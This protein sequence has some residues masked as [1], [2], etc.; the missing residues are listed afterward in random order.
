LRGPTDLFGLLS[1]A[2]DPLHEGHLQLQAVAAALLEGPVAF[3]LTA[4]NADKPP[5]AEADLLRRCRQFAGR[6]VAVSNA[7]TFVEKSRLFPGVT[8]VVGA[9]TA[10]RVV[11]PRFYGGSAGAMDEALR[12]IGA[13]G[14]RFLVAA[15]E[16]QQRLLTL[17][18]LE[19]PAPHA[20][21]FQPIPAETFRLDVSSTDIRRRQQVKSSP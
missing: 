21:I 12:E 14:C 13:H 17:D 2:F 15:R 3:E 11:Q 5:L 1:G 10:L 16:N 7:A 8:F 6:P 9:D 20:E 19:L 4:I 18:D